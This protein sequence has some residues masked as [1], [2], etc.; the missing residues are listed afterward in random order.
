MTIAVKTSIL[1]VGIN[2][3]F[4]HRFNFYLECYW[5]NLIHF[6]DGLHELGAAYNIQPVNNNATAQIEISKQFFSIMKSLSPHSQIGN[7]LQPY[8]ANEKGSS[9]AFLKQY[10]KLRCIETTIW[11]KNIT[12]FLSTTRNFSWDMNNF[13]VGVSAG[14][15]IVTN[16]NRCM[17][18][19][20]C[21]LFSCCSSIVQDNAAEFS[22]SSKNLPSILIPK[23]VE[24]SQSFEDFMAVHPL[25]TITITQGILFKGLFNLPPSF[26][27]E[28]E[29][30]GYES[31][32]KVINLVQGDLMKNLG[33]FV[34]S[35]KRMIFLSAKNQEQGSLFFPNSSLS[36]RRLALYLA[37]RQLELMQ[38]WL[39][40][41]Y[42]FM[43]DDIK[44]AKCCIAS[45]FVSSIGHWG[46]EVAHPIYGVSRTLEF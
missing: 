16:M 19:P 9:D 36:E 10:S 33:N 2:A 13:A 4:C 11:D 12:L 6:H 43:N 22:R 25:V 35:M 39:Y 18:Y 38:G 46:R 31:Q 28:Y 34:Q 24:N 21:F 3:G 7:A 37:A 44:Y 20:R 40:K 5:K 45:C 27:R 14:E 42:I 26:P 30:L 8:T 23:L 17:L 32:F 29:R 41:Y 1:F 15:M